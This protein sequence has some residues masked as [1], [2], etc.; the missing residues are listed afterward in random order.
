MNDNETYE[1]LADLVGKEAAQRVVESFAGT[2]LYIP[3][4][5]STTTRHELIR[6]EFKEGATYRELSVKYG[7]TE[8]HI[9]NITRRE[10]SKP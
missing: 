1:Q 7:Y 5:I 3:K 2:N 10:K 4:G 8:S 6:K 9:R